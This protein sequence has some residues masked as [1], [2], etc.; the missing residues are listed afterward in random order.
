MIK[1]IKDRGEGKTLDL[2][3][4]SAEEQIPMLIHGKRSYI[5]YLV[6]KHNIKNLPEPIEF[7][8]S[9]TV[10]ALKGRFPISNNLIIIDDIEITL[11]RLLGVGV[12]AISMDS[13]DVHLEIRTNNKK[14]FN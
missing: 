9:N 5:E 12:Y 7:K 14:Q 4:L 11:S 3:R 1:I 6:K 8:H 2:L 10:D 13:N